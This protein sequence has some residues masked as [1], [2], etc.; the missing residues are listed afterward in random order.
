MGSDAR[1]DESIHAPTRLRLCA[2]LRPVDYAEFST[3]TATLAVSEAN[4][5]KTIKNLVDLGYV[6][7]SKETSPDRP[8]S[9]RRTNVSLT[10]TGRLAFDRHLAALQDLAD[11]SRVDAIPTAPPPVP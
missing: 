1:F 3:I 6:A 4:L 8:D 9:R 2:L 11:S 5:S 7:T 10:G